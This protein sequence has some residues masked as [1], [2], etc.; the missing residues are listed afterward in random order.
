MNILFIGAV[1]PDEI[2]SK[3]K[4]NSVAGNNMQLGI[5]QGLS[6][7]PECNVY[8]LST[9]PIASFPKEKILG[10][11]KKKLYLS[12]G[13]LIISIPFINIFLFKQFTQ[14]FGLIIELFRW[15]KTHNSRNS[16]IVCYNSYPEWA[17]PI[18]F[19]SWIFKI[20]KICILADLP[21]FILK[22]GLIKHTIRKIQSKLTLSTIKKFD[23]LIVLN[24]EA[25]KKYA[26]QLPFCIVDGGINISKFMPP[27]NFGG[28]NPN[29]LSNNKKVIIFAGALD[30][31]N[32]I[33]N[34]LKAIKEIENRQ[35][36][37]RFFGEGS[38]KQDIIAESLKDERIEYNG[39]VPNNEILKIQ[40]NS[41]FLINPRP[42]NKP[43]SEVTFPSKI[44]EYMMSGVPILTTRLNGLIDEYQDYLIFIN[45]AP[46]LMAKDI[47][48]ALLM[49]EELLIS[50]SKLAYKYII[51]NKNWLIQA[52]KIYNF[53]DEFLTKQF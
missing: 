16:I 40:A 49:D 41:S 24:K 51:E 9:Y 44:L 30:E 34:L 43:L 4:G 31:H 37:F 36:I 15:K 11:R 3:Y 12:T 33:T 18:I 7:I 52:K 25:H 29:N 14:I 35:V 26:P 27:K 39:F 21:F 45:D 1:I 19:A 23:G 32:G 50:R 22:E 28:I 8:I 48:Q 2:C 46:L 13:E 17:F 47:E 38:L 53:L 10:M 5:I 42:I 20:K 6:K